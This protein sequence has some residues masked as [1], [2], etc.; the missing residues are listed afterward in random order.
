MAPYGPINDQAKS[1][2][3]GSIGGHIGPVVN[4]SGHRGPVGD[5]GTIGG[6]REPDHCCWINYGVFF[7]NLPL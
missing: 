4:Q 7:V 2:P 3:L 1:G 5:H 6:H